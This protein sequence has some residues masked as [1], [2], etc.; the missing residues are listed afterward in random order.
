MLSRDKIRM[1]SVPSPTPVTACPFSILLLLLILSRVYPNKRERSLS[2]AEKGSRKKPHTWLRFRESI[3]IIRGKKLPPFSF[4]E[5]LPVALA[6]IIHVLCM[7]L[8]SGVHGCGSAKGTYLPLLLG[9]GELVGAAG[10]GCSG[11]CN[12]ACP[13]WVPGGR[14]GKKP[15]GQWVAPFSDGLFAARCSSAVFI[16]QN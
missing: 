9:A 7:G 14:D 1:E 13:P 8:L 15:L 3:F 10:G 4:L 12:P 5:A 16:T 11:H 6:L 2:K